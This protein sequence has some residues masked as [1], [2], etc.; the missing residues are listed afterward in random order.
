MLFVPTMAA[1]AQHF[2]NPRK[3]A[4]ALGIVASGSG[5][6]GIILPILLNN[7]F[8]GSAGFKGGVLATSGLI[9]GLQLIAVCLVRPKYPAK[10]SKPNE[11]INFNATLR[12]FFADSA[13]A[14]VVAA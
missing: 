1:V 11:T 4:L 8:K 2:H 12:K 6:G 14:C 10:T 3:R 5:V 7:L 9:A 13:Y